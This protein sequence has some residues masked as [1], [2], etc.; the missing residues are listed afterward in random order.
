MLHVEREAGA[1][2]T[3]LGAMVLHACEST[4]GPA[5]RKPGGA[6]LSYPELGRAA[7]EIAAGLIELG[8]RHGDRVAILSD[9]RPEWTLVDCGALVAGAIVV[10]IYQ[11]NS[12]RECEYV[13]Q[14]SGAR[15]VV[16]EDE[17]QLAKVAVRPAPLPRS[18]A[19]GRDGGG[20]R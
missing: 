7:T 14:H 4:S 18:R 8:V 6:D 13:L 12:P 19:R 1:R 20:G 10:P 17:D 5:L 9:T 16:C 11:T 15:V 2:A 3:T